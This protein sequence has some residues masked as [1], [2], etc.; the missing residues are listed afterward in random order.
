VVWGES[1]RVMMHLSSMRVY[2]EKNVTGSG[3]ALH[4]RV[5]RLS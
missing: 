4:G 5:N 1:M 3:F 2:R